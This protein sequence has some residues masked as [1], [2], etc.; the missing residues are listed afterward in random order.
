LKGSEIVKKS[1][2]ESTQDERFRSIYHEIVFLIGTIITFFVLFKVVTFNH[3][4]S[5]SMEN[6]IRINSIICISRNVKTINRYDII[7]F[8]KTIEKDGKK[9]SD[10]L[11]KRV[12]GLPGDTLTFSDNNIYVNGDLVDD[13]FVKYK[14]FTYKNETIVVPD[15]K[16]FVMGDN[17][18]S[19]YDSRN[20]G[21][22][23]RSEIKGKAIYTLLPLSKSG[24]LVYS[25]NEE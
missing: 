12:I 6:T 4:P 15:E 20:W 17:R 25:K 3:V 19:S 11:I 22:V 1:N 16:Y 14:T 23:D 9:I 21:F 24:S 8:N 13:S 18:G 2:K 5:E 10:N 7:T